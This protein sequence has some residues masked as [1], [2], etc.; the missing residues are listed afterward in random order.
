MD[1]R[2][3]V[4]IV[5]E[6]E[7][8]SL[9]GVDIPG[10]TGVFLLTIAHEAVVHRNFQ[11]VGRVGRLGQ[12]ATRAFVFMDKTNWKQSRRE[13]ASQEHLRRFILENHEAVEVAVENAQSSLA[14][15]RCPRRAQPVNAPA[16]VVTEARQL[17]EVANK[18]HVCPFSVFDGAGKTYLC[19]R[20]G[21]GCRMHH[22]L[23]E[24]LTWYRGRAYLNGAHYKTTGR[25]PD[26]YR[27]AECRCSNR[28]SNDDDTVCDANV[29]ILHARSR[30]AAASSSSSSS[31]SRTSAAK[32]AFKNKFIQYPKGVSS[33]S[34]EGDAR[35]ETS[36]SSCSTR[37][38]SIAAPAAAAALA[39]A[40]AVQKPNAWEKPLL[41]ICVEKSTPPVAAE[42]PPAEARRLSAWDKSP[43]LLFDS[44][45][46]GPGAHAIE[47]EAVAVAVSHSSAHGRVREEV[48]AM[49]LCQN[50][51]FYGQCNRHPSRLHLHDSGFAAA[52]E[53][54]EKT[55]AETKVCLKGF[56]EPE[57]CKFGSACHRLHKGD[58]RLT[59]GVIAAFR[60]FYIRTT[61]QLSGR[62]LSSCRVNRSHDIR[63][64]YFLHK[65]D[66]CSGGGS[67]ANHHV[68]RHPAAAAETKKEKEKKGGRVAHSNSDSNSDRKAA[69]AMKSPF[70]ALDESSDTDENGS[71]D[72][73]AL[74]AKNKMADAR[75][76]PFP[77]SNLPAL[78]KT[79][80]TGVRMGVRKALGAAT[81][82]AAMTDSDDEDDYEDDA[83]AR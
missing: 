72:E 1:P 27:S 29:C 15:I 3:S 64:C 81:S 82:W 74:V 17:N 7:L 76:A 53:A 4:V 31:S 47:P 66:S 80:V 25:T 16:A 57:K 44:P 24:E 6:H 19:P 70:A 79:G 32:P 48:P 83:V 40:A 42:T 36:L 13:A 14:A 58:A 69:A 26:C 67:T 71:E 73:D 50:C 11:T 20:Q 9:E 34:R 18:I 78:A 75:L 52:A 30:A 22:P 2:F 62:P 10:L 37:C 35:S 51:F 21:T 63:F 45:R 49:E 12:A 39:S 60:S 59:A 54:F 61:A 8:K 65:E 46:P 28:N 55:F 23:L 41:G 77:S 5:R 56:F 43:S 38:V 68:C 33:D